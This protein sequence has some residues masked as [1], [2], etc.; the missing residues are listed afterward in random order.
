METRD[1]Y[2]IQ[3]GLHYKVDAPNVKSS[4]YWEVVAINGD[5]VE[6]KSDSTSYHRTFNHYRLFGMKE[7]KKIISEE[8]EVIGEIDGAEMAIERLIWWP[9]QQRRGRKPKVNV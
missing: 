2:P 7:A 3:V 4:E 9:P 5:E 6:C 8:I 1:N